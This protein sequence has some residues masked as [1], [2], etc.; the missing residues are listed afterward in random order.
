M[1]LT[2]D[3]PDLDE[4]RQFELTAKLAEL[5]SDAADVKAKRHAE[6]SRNYM[7]T[8]SRS[9]GSNTRPGSGVRDSEIYPIIRNRI[10]WMTDQKVQF[11]VY[12]AVDPMSKFATFE[13]AL[14]HHLELVLASNWQVQGWYAQQTLM[15]WDAAVCGAGILKAV[16][17]SGLDDGLGNVAIQRRDPWKIY[18]DPQ[19]TSMDD[20]SYLFEV[21]RMTIDDI[22]RKF[23]ETS[24]ALL[25]EAYSKGDTGDLPGRPRLDRGSMRNYMAVPGN[26][27]GN[28]GTA[29]G[30]PGQGTQAADD[31]FTQGINVYE[32]WIRENVIFDRETTDPLLGET[33]QVV[34]DEWR[35]IVY[36]G[37]HVL[38]DTTATELWQHNHHPYARYVDDETGE[39]W[40]VPLVSYLAP[41]QVAIDRILAA[42]QSN[43]ELTGNPI[44]MDV[45]GSGLSRTQ[46]V[47]RAGLRLQLDQSM[48]NAQGQKPGWLSPPQF[49]TDALQMVQL[50]LQ[51][52]ERISGLSGPQR[53]NQ[54]TGRQAQQTVQS[55]QEAG[56][57]SIRLSQ[58][59]QELALARV[60]MLLCHLVAQNYTTPRVVA[61]VG[62]KGSQTSLLLAARHFYSPSRN[63]KTGK[64]DLTPMA[65]SLNVNAGSDRPTSRQARIAEADALFAMHAV[66]QQYVL[67]A[68]QVS[69]WQEIVQRMAEAAK[70]AAAAQHAAGGRG[71]PKGEPH[72]PGTGHEH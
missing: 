28:P 63:P 35:V 64:Y 19:A 22:Q 30:T 71:G 40:P 31:V 56:F 38:L 60:G 41:C 29:W 2:A 69:D 21:N 46:I 45:S 24:Q 36:T 26:I 68:H 65:F 1:T 10:A 67:Q 51:A 48:M 43:V 33:E 58:R 25:E 72:G 12:P 6:W 53:G 54:P 61:I 4:Y 16:W 3:P 49:S 55:A 57:V 59:N 50:W 7:L 13:Q 47:N 42:M 11:D 14:G 5:F 70:A 15:L 8:F 62:D 9:S 37:R 52:M 39:F 27:P 32:C 44:F 20:L 17:D 66:D 23:P 18:P 34:T